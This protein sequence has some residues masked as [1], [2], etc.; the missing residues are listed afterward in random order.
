MYIRINVEDKDIYY[1]ES[2]T[3][4][5]GGTV[6]FISGPI[7]MTI[8]VDLVMSITKYDPRA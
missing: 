3:F 1:T 6:S 5:E 4:N 8:P 2:I 7:S